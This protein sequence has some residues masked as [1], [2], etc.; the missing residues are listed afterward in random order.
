ML[1]DGRSCI[2]PQTAVQLTRRLINTFLLIHK[3]GT[4]CAIE[5]AVESDELSKLPC[6]D[7]T[8]P[9]L[10]QEHHSSG[11]QD[12]LHER[13][14]GKLA[15]DHDRIPFKSRGPRHYDGSWSY[16]PTIPDDDHSHHP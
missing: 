4:A 15:T 1:R 3:F 11:S 12:F 5:M 10:G 9:V 16:D 2:A 8:V 14:L 7:T 13:R 6:F